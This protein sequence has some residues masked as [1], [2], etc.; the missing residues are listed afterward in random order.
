M[1]LSPEELLKRDAAHLWH[2]Y[3][4]VIRSD[5]V[6]PVRSA[7]GCEIELMDG[8]RLVDGMASWWC[9]IHGYNHP[10]LNAALRAQ[11][12][13]FAH[14]MFGG[15]THEPAVQLAARLVQLTPEPLS[16]VFFCDS[17]SVAVEVAL[18][19]A[20]QYQQARGYPERQ[21]FISLRSGYH[22]DTLGAMSLC[23]P[24]T[25]MHRLFAGILP[26]QYF[27]PAPPCAFGEPC[28]P[29]DLAPLEAL[30]QRHRRE[31]AGLIL[32]PIVQGAGGM[33]FYSADYLRAVRDL[34][35]A[36]DL[37]LIADEIATGFGRTGRWFACEHAGIAPD[38]LTL[39]KA[40][41]GGYLSL[42]ATLTTEPIARTISGG[43]AG[44][45][46]HGPTFMGNPLA[47]AVA[48]ASIELLLASDWQ[49]SI[50]RIQRGLMQGLAPCRGSPGVADVRVLGA[51]G[52][53]ELE[54]PV[55]LAEVQ[56]QLVEQ[57]VW[58]RPFGRLL[59]TMPPYLITED[60]LARICAAMC[61]VVA[62]QYPR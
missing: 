34:C 57:G 45:F 13:R 39:G 56:R 3:S 6:Y 29:E 60:Q 8:R 42:A 55:C 46:M 27:A 20:V 17:G 31:L 49:A 10:Q 30:I 33:R 41:T 53:I 36:Y 4:S 58:L 28:A 61:R 54:K 19:M 1:A 7:C 38:I 21:R 48:N 50:Q 59:Y 18:K 2:P 9:V 43:E 23:D 26:K 62:D 37:L 11:L 32:E 16:R 22:G 14:I 47:C 5:P 51:I 12:D 40:L 52:V 44:A 24:I 15:F 35:N 25:G